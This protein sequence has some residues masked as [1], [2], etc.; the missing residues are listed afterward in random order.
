MIPS[1]PWT[2]MSSPQTQNL[3][4]ISGWTQRKTSLAN[5]FVMAPPA[6]TISVE[7]IVHVLII[8]SARMNSAYVSLNALEKTV[9]TMDVAGFVEHATKTARKSVE[10]MASANVPFPPA[11]R[12]AARREK[13]AI[14]RHAAVHCAPTALWPVGTMAAEAPV[15]LV[16]KT[17]TA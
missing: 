12:V 3:L 10:K 8:M 1:I 15:A 17:R 11:T 14:T 5:P 6:E 2:D 16:V 4:R 9:A 7:E 13:H